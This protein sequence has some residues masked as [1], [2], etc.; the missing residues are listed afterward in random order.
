[1]YTPHPVS[2]LALSFE[3]LEQLRDQLVGEIAQG[4]AQPNQQIKALPAFVCLPKTELN[5]DVMV[6][7]AGGTNVRAAKVGF[8]GK[9]V[10]FTKK[11]YRDEF[12]M[13]EAQVVG[14]IDADTFFQRQADLIH[15]VSDEPEF[16]LGYCFSYPSTNTPDNDARLVT[17]TKGINVE[18]VIGESL[19]SKICQAIANNGQTAHKVPVLNDTV[20]TLVAG[21]WLAD[22]DQYIGLIAGT[23]LNAAA[24]YR[25][26]Q[27]GKLSAEEKQGWRDDEVMAVNLEVGN[28]HPA[29]LTEYDDALNERRVDDNPGKQRVEKAA[30][31]RYIAPIFG[32]IVGRDLCMS[33]KDGF[34]FD[35]DDIA[36]HAGQVTLLRHYPDAYIAQTAQ[37]IIDRSAD[38]TAVSLAA[39]IMGQNAHLLSGDAADLQPV[40]TGIL[41]EGTLFWKTEGY[42]ERVARQL[43]RLTP[44]HLSAKFLFNDRDVSTNFIGVGYATLAMK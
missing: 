22:C 10:Q 30:S 24:Y 34:A 21:A 39:I 35:P 9:E 17:W 5:G 18:G 12:L 7:D 25:V 20:T 3:Q 13:S 43:D 33:L 42:K 26:D 11:K 23:G 4:L 16:D 32:Q 41:V 44:D 2:N 8:N 38:F 36:T 29:F 19:R 1:M 37:A 27:I 14:A 6:L 31:G 40:T 15:K 28:F